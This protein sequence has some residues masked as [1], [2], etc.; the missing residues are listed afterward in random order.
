MLAEEARQSLLA[1]DLAN[2]ATPAY[3]PERAAV[4]AFGALLAVERASGALVGELGLGVSLAAG[5]VELSQ[6]PLR[7]TGDPLDVALQGEG[8]LV[9]HTPAGRRYLRGGRLAV[10][11][12][13]RLVTST[14]HPLLDDQG[15]VVVVEGEGFSLA[16]DGTVSVGGRP[17]ARLAVVTLEGPAR[18]GDGLY[19]G[20][21]G[22]RPDSTSV[23]QGWLEGSS[24]DTARTMVDAL[25]S[26]RA[27]EA[28]QRVIRAID[29]SLG[30]AI[31]G[32]QA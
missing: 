7:E 22:T 15:R 32:V 14:G 20:R 5:E 1:S 26:L 29:D 16:A 18:E 23:R 13:G 28:L 11:G 6:G 3:K 27:F 31:N 17:V 9:V 8:F 4:H 24:V 10:D 30:R 19:G 12:Q 21:P 2:V 25:T